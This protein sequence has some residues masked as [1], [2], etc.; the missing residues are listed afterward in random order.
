MSKDIIKFR[1]GVTDLKS[2]EKDDEL[3]KLS[4]FESKETEILEY[5]K[6]KKKVYPAKTMNYIREGIIEYQGY[7]S[8]ETLKVLAVKISSVFPMSCFQI[9]IEKKHG[10]IRM[11]FD[12]YDREKMES[13]YL[14]EAPHNKL[15][16]MIINELRLQAAACD[17][18]WYRYIMIEDYCD[19]PNLF[20]KLKDW[21]KKN[22]ND[23]LSRKLLNIFGFCEQICNKRLKAI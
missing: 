18:K 21:V 23:D 19:D 16:A 13:F 10:R 22:N 2:S 15:S 1:K 7:I 9:L 8:M 17:S 3:W 20:I 4:T 14:Y 12:C 5:I 11:L 6:E